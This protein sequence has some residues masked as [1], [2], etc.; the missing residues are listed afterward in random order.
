MSGAAAIEVDLDFVAGDGNAGWAAVEGD[1][2][3]SSV[4]FS[5][6][7]DAEETAKGVAGAHAEGE[8]CGGG[9]RDQEG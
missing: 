3:A 1:A 9:E 2:D 4:G 5:P 8:G 6:G 7:G